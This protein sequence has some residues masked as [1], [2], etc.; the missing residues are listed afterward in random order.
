MNPRICMEVIVEFLD[1]DPDKPIVSGCIDNRHNKVSDNLPE[2]KTR[3]TYKTGM[4]E[5]NGFNE[6][7][8]VG[9]NGNISVVH[10]GKSSQIF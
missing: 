2:Y 1:G 8:F 4:H 6:L 10:L 5:G 7:R 9:K 3:S